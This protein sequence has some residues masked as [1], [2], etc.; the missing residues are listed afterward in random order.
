MH[1]LRDLMIDDNF[2]IHILDNRH[3]LPECSLS[4]TPLPEDLRQTLTRYLLAVLRRDSRRRQFGRFQPTSRVLQACADLQQAASQGQPVSA[5]TFLDVSQRLAR[6]LFEAMRRATD[7]G[8]PPR[9]GDI[10]PG[11]LL[12]G[13]FYGRDTATPSGPYLFLIKVELETALQRQVHRLA[14][15]GMQTVLSLCEGLL[16]KFRAEH[17]HK[18]ALIQFPTDTSTF[19]VLMTDPQ[20]GK[21][22][23]AKFFSEVFLDTEPF[24]TPDEQ[25]ELLFTRTHAWVTAHED[26]LSP[27]EQTD[28]LHSVRSLIADHVD[29]AEPV[30]PRDLVATLPL[31]DAR[32]AAVIHE[33][34]QSFQETLTA[35]EDNGTRLLLDRELRLDTVPASVSK[36][37]RT[38]ELDGGVRISGEQEAIERLFQTPPH[39]V[40]D[41][42]E[43]TIRTATFRHLL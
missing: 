6:L 21:H 30:V 7:N 16:P 15:G 32:P 28:V 12:V 40:D 18:T 4:L 20:G 37:R 17:V 19:D 25:A 10:T 5:A 39:R 3:S 36:T 26:A 8:V 9:P 38:Y 2:V 23:V 35:P 29:S 43:F 33:L 34:R 13:L 22:G 41:M 24:H 42:T 11:D 14:Q 27:Q 31:R 1:T